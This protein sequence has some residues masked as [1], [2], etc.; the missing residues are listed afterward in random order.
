MFNK[1]WSN[2]KLDILWLSDKA[3]AEKEKEKF[4][5]YLKNKL[6]SFV[7]CRVLKR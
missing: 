1:R 7:A 3:T 4:W 5:K 2:L 6:R